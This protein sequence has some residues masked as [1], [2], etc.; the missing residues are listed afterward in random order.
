M[1]PLSRRWVRRDGVRLSY[2]VLGGGGDCALLML[3]GYGRSGSS[4]IP[5]LERVGPLPFRVVLVDHRGTGESARPWRPYTLATLADDAAAVLRDGA[6]HAPA[7]VVGDSMGGMVAQHLALRHPRGIG[8]LVLSASSAR[9]DVETAAFV[10]SLPLTV[11]ATISTNVRVW[12]MCDRLLLHEA[13]SPSQAHDLMA[14]LRQLQRGEPYSR[15]N[16]LLQAVAVSSHRTVG[17][18]GGVHVPV[19][20]IVGAGDRV[21]SPRNSRVLS[22]C[23]PHARLTILKDTGHAIPFERPMEILNAITRLRARSRPVQARP[24]L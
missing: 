3:A 19:E 1:S 18:L 15:L 6:G 8:G 7:I 12:T 23:L 5:W 4:W 10:R 13:K 24:G 11:A 17:R 14:P 2:Q 22:Q 9:V 21:L 16:S 20:V